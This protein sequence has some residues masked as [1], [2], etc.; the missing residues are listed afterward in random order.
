MFWNDRH[1][2]TLGSVD[3]SAANSTTPYEFGQKAFLKRFLFTPTTAKD[4]TKA[5]ITVTKRKAD[6]STSSTVL[7]TFDVPASAPVNTPYYV[8]VPLPNNTAHTLVDGSIG[9]DALPDWF[10]FDLGDEVVLTSD[11]GGAA[12]VVTFFMEIQSLHSQ[13]L[14]SSYVRSLFTAA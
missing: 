8:D 12:G 5:V 4:A 9:Y 13:V 6:G 11:G 1:T 3:V 7:G 2:I 14:P 10:T